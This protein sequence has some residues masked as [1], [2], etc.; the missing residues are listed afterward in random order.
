M[1]ILICHNHYR[2]RA[3]EARVVEE[4]R[5]LLES[6]GHDVRLF[7]ADNTDVEPQSLQ[8]QVGLATNA[9]YSRSSRAKLANILRIWRPD[10]AHVHNTW[11]LLSPSIYLELRHQ[12]IPTVQTQHNFRWF[13]AA[14]TF[15]RDNQV[16]LDCIEKPG[17]RLHGI[18]HRCYHGNRTMS[19][20]LTATQF[21]AHSI[22]NIYRRCID[23]II[24]HTDFIRQIYLAQGFS[25]EQLRIKPNF[26]PPLNGMP[27][28][29]GS[30]IVFMGRL[31]ATKGVP[32]LLAAAEM[33]RIPIT[34][35]GSGPLENQVREAA[36]KLPNLTFLGA[37]P[38]D[39]CLSVLRTA[40]AMVIP[41]EW[42]ESFPMTFVEAMAAGK[43]VI[44]SALGSLQS[45]I[46][47][48]RAGLLFQAGSAADLAAA[49]DR[50]GSDDALVTNLAMRAHQYYTLHLTPERNYEQLTTI[51][52][53]VIDLKR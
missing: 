45:L 41:S 35:M 15:H 42:Y 28:E 50:L 23:R 26:M 6:H 18:V 27:G 8:E 32:T 7:S 52:Q 14:A 2:I 25:A 21:W 48:S 40:R 3:G 12:R 9:I 37:Q 5:R 17:G 49:L 30:G 1:R 34:I 39:A 31:D 19:T 36:A 46:E 33:T 20:V 13:C 29:P 47:E 38:H 10:V 44:G 22:R 16:C 4:E 11:F 24:V 43:P 53:E 51:Y